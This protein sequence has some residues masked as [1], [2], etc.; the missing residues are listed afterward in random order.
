MSRVFRILGAGEW[1]LAIA[2]HLALQDNDVE[3]YIRNPKVVSELQ[4]KNIYNG[5]NHKLNEKIRYYQLDVIAGISKKDNAIN[6]LAPSSDGFSEI[7]DNYAEYLSLYNEIVWLT[8]GLDHSSGSLFHNII[9]NKIPTNIDKCI[10]SGPSFARDLL[11]KK[12]I[13]VTAAS[14]S[15]DLFDLLADSMNTNY[16]KLLFTNNIVG[17]EISGIIKNISGILAGALTANGFSDEYIDELIRL[18]QVEVLSITEKIIEKN[19]EY[20]I[21][22]DD[23]NDLLV[24]PACYGDMH[25]TCFYNTSRNRQLGLKLKG[26]FN[27]KKIMSGI[28]T[29]EGY[30]STSTLFFNNEKFNI[31]K[32]VLSAY[33]I[34]YQKKN[35]ENVLDNLFK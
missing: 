25:L 7:V 20:A 17:V 28:G 22:D 5:L 1:G 23:P 8:K 21:G 24:S 16:F 13:T 30:L 19:K 15:T 2:N 27:T 9:D 33:S 26:D 14:T 3:V 18:S 11:N 4:S 32:V 31:G 6:I 34:L 10:I 29:V 12:S 35:I